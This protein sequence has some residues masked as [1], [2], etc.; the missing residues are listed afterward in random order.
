MIDADWDSLA[1]LSSGGNFEIDLD[2]PRQ[3]TTIDDQPMVDFGGDLLN[4][5]ENPWPPDW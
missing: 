1:L 5:Y 4:N 2:N 3:W